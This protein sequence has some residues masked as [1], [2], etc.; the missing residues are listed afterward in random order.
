MSTL[1]NGW[2]VIVLAAAVGVLGTLLVV[3]QSGEFMPSAYG[4]VSPGVVTGNAVAMLGQTTNSLTPLFIVD[5]KAQTILVYEYNHS[6]RKMY[7]RIARSFTADRE[8]QDSGFGSQ[9][10]YKG[11]SVKEVQDMI[12]GK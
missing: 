3:R 4:Q 5:T 2:L 6:N 8:L 12:R 10:Q 1:K 11:P 7:L 9:D